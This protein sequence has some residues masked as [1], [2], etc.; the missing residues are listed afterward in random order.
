[1][2]DFIFS[3][4]YLKNDVTFLL[5][6]IDIQFDE[7]DKKEK[8]IQSGKKH[9]SEMLSPEYQP[10]EEYLKV[11]YKL[12]KIN[13]DTF[14]QDIL[15]FAMNIPENSII[16][17]LARAGTPIGVLAKRVL[18][19][20]KN[21]NLPHYSISIIR[22]KGIDEN[23]L[24]YI[25]KKHPNKNIF[26]ID[27]WTGKGV[28][29]RELKKYVAKFNE[30]YNTKISDKLA[31]ISDISGKADFSVSAQDY[32][33]PS[34]ALNSTISGLVSRTILNT[35]FI[36]ENDF[37]G[38]KFYE[39]FRDVDLSL[40]FVDEVL[41]KIENLNPT[42]KNFLKQDKNQEKICENYIFNIMKQYSIADI[43]FVKPGIAETTRVLLRR[44]PEMVLVKNIDDLAIQHLLQLA[45]EKRAKIVEIS[46]LPYTA[47]GIIK[48]VVK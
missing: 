10:S 40:W 12:L 2:E 3:G 13:L 5:K 23:A 42:L 36:K 46:D 27:G 39:E 37:H 11:F 15:N 38:C 16:V 43:N 47:V 21:Q 22:D 7:V 24:K 48:S 29:N 33:I 25:L 4:S 20:R 6:K 1:M 32:V 31:V 26:F 8:A 34:S 28:I 35:K 18:Q 45:K 30:K 17:S 19:I 44:V 14:A 41:N 9:Y